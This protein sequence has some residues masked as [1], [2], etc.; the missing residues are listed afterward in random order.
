MITTYV[1]RRDWISARI[2][3]CICATLSVV[4]A[5]VVAPAAVV[6]VAAAVVVVATVVVVACVVVIFKVIKN[7]LC[8]NRYLKSLR[9]FFLFLPS[10]IFSCIKSGTLE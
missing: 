5:T 4:G 9:G 8:Q 6:V 3:C 2:S 7:I 10:L 1:L